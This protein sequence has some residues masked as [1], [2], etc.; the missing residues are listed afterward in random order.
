VKWLEKKKRLY[1]LDSLRGIA[2]LSVV[3]FHYTT[4]Y[5][6]LYGHM[7][8]N[9]IF[10]VKYGYLGVHLFFIIS[11]FVIYMTILN[12]NSVK[13]FLLKRITRLYPAYIV[14]V[15]LTTVSITLFGIKG[16]NKSL[17]NVLLNFTMLQDVIPKTG[18]SSVDGSYWSLAVEIYF[19]LICSILFLF[20]TI[21]K[22]VIVS[23]LAFVC[24]FLIKGLYKAHLIHPFIG[25]HVLIQYSNL[26]IAGIM[27]YKLKDSNL[28]R[29]Y[30][31]L[32]LS[33]LYEFTFY[34]LLTSGII[35]LIFLLF[36]ALIKNKLG[37]LNF[38]PLIFLGSISYS[39]YL[40]HQNIGYIIINNLE[41]NGFT[42]EIFIS[43][44]ILFNIVLA[45]VITFF[46]EK[47]T[48]KYLRR[49]VNEKKV[50]VKTNQKI[51]AD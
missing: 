35:L 12:C 41:K 39:L 50:R 46:I 40:I 5:G 13:E 19:Y 18:I 14:A 48:Q 49:K 8:K 15:L 1:E 30:F 47:P 32:I 44:P 3:L 36:L 4:L 25:D 10:D 7:K 34:D 11:G 9:Y 24:L 23:L 42:N 27:F 2:A 43:I 38:R 33:I 28:I 20:G 16:M 21:K 37:F 29:Y 17:I 45:T 22:P 51:I 26:F 31:I 6:N